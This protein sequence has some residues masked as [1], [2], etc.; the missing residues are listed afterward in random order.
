MAAGCSTMAID[1][2]VI[3]ADGKPVVGALV[4]AY[5]SPCNAIVGEDGKFEIVCQPGTYDLVISA[6]GYTS[7]EAQVE[8]P[9]RKRYDGGKHLL[10]RIPENEGLFLRQGATY[11]DMTPS[12]LVRLLETDGKLTRRRFC[13]DPEKGGPTEVAAGV[14]ALFDNEHPGWRPWRLDEEGCAYR[15][16]KN[17][18]HKWTVEY[19]EKATYETRELNRGKS[20]ALMELKP[21]NYFISDWKG[22][23]VKS[24][25]KELNAYT[26][27]WIRVP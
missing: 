2:Q 1:G 20:I 5:G 22:F 14:H 26:G 10:V 17:A 24:P 23:F 16:T 6:E 9:E 3:D 11:L 21:G 13:L 7:E 27:Y 4:T 25:D 8:A 18:E 12:H 15:D 19:R